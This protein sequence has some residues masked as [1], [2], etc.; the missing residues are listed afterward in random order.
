M[1]LSLSGKSVLALVI[2]II[3]RRKKTTITSLCAGNMR[4]KFGQG[5]TDFSSV[6]LSLLYMY[7]LPPDHFWPHTADISLVVCRKV[8]GKLG[9][10]SDNLNF[11]RSGP[12]QI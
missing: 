12:G 10:S 5:A 6:F 7:V 4:V 11:E 1:Y 9:Q 8:S 3:Q 2:L